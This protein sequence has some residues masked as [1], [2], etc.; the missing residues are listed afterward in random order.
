M[1]ISATASAGS[2]ASSR[3]WPAD[4][5][6]EALCQHL[7][8]SL[9]DEPQPDDICVLAVRRRD[10]PAGARIPGVGDRAARRG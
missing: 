7:V 1:T 4:G 5:P 9:A 2:P 6:V 3:A 10:E 8:T